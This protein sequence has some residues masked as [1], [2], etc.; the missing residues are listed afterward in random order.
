MPG[1]GDWQS[2][3]IPRFT[4]DAAGPLCSD[5]RLDTSRDVSPDTVGSR[6]E[7]YLLLFPDGLQVVQASYRG[8]AGLPMRASIPVQ[9][10][11][12]RD[13]VTEWN[14]LGERLGTLTNERALPWSARPS[15]RPSTRQ[16]GEPMDGN[17]EPAD[18]PAEPAGAAR[19][20]MM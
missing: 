11:T 17:D 18:G 16:A 2:C 4:R 20:S 12:L 8:S 13:W 15:G 5:R 9:G 7:L 1:H 3:V 6:D 10:G 19:P 14:Q